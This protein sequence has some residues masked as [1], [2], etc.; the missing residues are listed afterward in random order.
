[1][2]YQSQPKEPA[3]IRALSKMRAA[4]VTLDTDL[5]FRVARLDNLNRAVAILE[6]SAEARELLDLAPFLSE[7]NFGELED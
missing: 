2:V 4:V 1:M 5:K 7:L 3:S 6:S